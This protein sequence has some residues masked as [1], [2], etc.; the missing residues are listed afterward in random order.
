ML[1]RLRIEVSESL[2]TLKWGGLRVTRGAAIAPNPLIEVEFVEGSV[3]VIS[4]RLL[5]VRWKSLVRAGSGQSERFREVSG[6]D[7]L[8]VPARRGRGRSR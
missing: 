1:A 6:G 4:P 2:R 8:E 5:T 7:R 3:S